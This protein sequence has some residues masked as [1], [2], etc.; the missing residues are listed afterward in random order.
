MPPPRRGPIFQ[1]LCGVGKLSPVVAIGWGLTAIAIAA[2]LLLSVGTL[3]LERCPGYAACPSIQYAQ[4]LE[5]DPDA[6]ALTASI[7]QTETAA[8]TEAV[9]DPAQKK[10]LLG[11]L[12]YFDTNLSVRSNQACA[13]CHAADAGFSGGVSV[14]G[15]SGVTFPGSVALR[16]VNRNPPSAAYAVFAPV[17]SY[18]AVTGDFIGGTF[19]DQR[20]TGEITG[21]PAADQAL[22]P[23]VN[24]LEMALPDEACAV[25]RVTEGRYATLFAQVWGAL[26]I[27]WPANARRICGIAGEGGSLRVLA[28]STQDRA[29]AEQAYKNIALSL[30]AFEASPSVSPFS[31]KYDAVVAGKAHLTAQ[32]A[33]GFNLF[34]DK[35]RCT[36]CHVAA[37]LHPLLTNFAAVNTGIPANRRLPFYGES[38]DDG[39]GLIANPAGA[40]YIDQ[41]TGAMLAQSSK[42]EW[43]QLA[44]R[45]NGAFQVPTL[46][47]VAALPRPGFTRAYM[48]NGYFTSLAEIVHFYNT[49]D[50]LPRCAEGKGTV[51]VNCWPAPEHPANLNTQIGNLG[52]TKD[53]EAALV[54]FLGTFTDGY[55]AGTRP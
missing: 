52:L 47:N 31:S 3:F 40:A 6:L 43:R 20:A 17:L 38:V 45:F 42:P 4:I 51:G 18:R 8:L 44:P 26:S 5:T 54:A 10:I 27:R 39:K 23:F 36:L 14:Y 49:R 53:E 37:G 30:A 1:G 32:E 13:S 48:H 16:T 19:W 46:R 50:V 28:L 34:L 7:A 21:I 24:P 11:K 29:A 25:L 35:A 33:E 2:V 41:G 15:A 9:A 22:S 12:I 55:M